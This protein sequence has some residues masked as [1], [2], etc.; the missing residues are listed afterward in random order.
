MKLTDIN[1]IGEKKEHYLNKLNINTVE[2]LIYYFPREYEDRKDLKDLSFQG[3]ALV[4]LEILTTPVIFYPRK[5]LNLTKFL[6]TDGTNNAEIV[7]FNQPFIKRIFKAGS[8]YYF[9]GPIVHHQRNIQ[10]TNPVFQ[11]F[12]GDQL[13]K[14]V[15]IYPLTKGITQNDMRK[16]IIQ[17][18]SYYRNS[19]H[20]ILPI[21]MVKAQRFMERRE[22]IETIH[23][24]KD[25]AQLEEAHRLLQFEKLLTVELAIKSMRNKSCNGKLPYHEVTEIKEFIKSLPFK[26]TNAQ[27]NVYHEIKTDLLSKKT[28]NR[29]V[30][31]DVGSGK[32]IVAVLAMLFA[33]YN[34]YQSAIMAP[35]EILASQHYESFKKNLKNTNIRIAELKGS[36]SEKE[37]DK[38]KKDIRAG[39][40]DIIIGTHAI[41]QNDVVFNDLGLVVIDEQHRFGVQ[42]R[43]YLNNKGND[44]ETLVMTATPIP[45]TLL[46]TLYDDLDLSIIDE[47]PPG[48]KEVKTIA[49]DQV[50]ENRV[51][52]FIKKQIKEGKQGYI[53]CPLI[54]DSEV[55]DIES[56]EGLYKRVSDK[57]K[58]ARSA[59]LHGKMKPDEKAHIMDNFLS[60]DIDVLFS[61]TVIEVGVNVSNAN[62]IC[63]YNAERF[64]LSQL[65]QLRGR[66]GRSDE[67]SYCILI[68]GDLNKESYRRMRIMENTNDGFII[69]NEDLK[70]RGGGD[71]LGTRQSGSEQIDLTLYT[72]KTIRDILKL[73]DYIID[74]KLLNLREFNALSN[75]VE[76]IKNKINENIILN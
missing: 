2:D 25:F 33:Y 53:V 58:P 38:I 31:G 54:E 75:H 67:Q 61:T 70:I 1:G 16:F 20:N 36:L 35:T 51:I 39:M 30:Q 56:L 9:Y 34:S 52:G 17:A 40:I 24:P 13:G 64:G 22:A 10:I 5:G 74:N 45:R 41:I 21:S 71:I 65:H 27:M 47:L 62:F 6:A 28:M 72:E 4:Q 14:I 32:T 18:L 73:S 50:H 19:I 44:V 42:Q 11:K 37:K 43:A 12:L 57:I 23:Q 63:I 29:M 76:R 49:I 55:L 3:K 48:R 59:I 69:A 66:V 7:F 15:P 46:L 68:N 60:K 26:L 8:K